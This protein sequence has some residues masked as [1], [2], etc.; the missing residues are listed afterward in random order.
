VGGGGEVDDD[1]PVGARRTVTRWR[2]RPG[3][4]TV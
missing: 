4:L 1:V 2:D 3:L